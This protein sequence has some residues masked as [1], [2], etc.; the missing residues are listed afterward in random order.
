LSLSTR[1]YPF[2]ERPNTVSGTSK[3]IKVYGLRYYGTNY[4]VII[5]NKD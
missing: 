4:G 5:I 2:I 3:S 1:R